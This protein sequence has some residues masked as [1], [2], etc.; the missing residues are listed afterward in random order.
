MTNYKNDFE[1]DPIIARV[2]HTLKPLPPT[3]PAAVARVLTAVHGQPRRWSERVMHRFEFLR[4]P[5]LSLAGAT[6]VA[7][8]ALLIGFVSRGAWD[9]TRDT[10]PVVTADVPV[11]T[12][13]P[14]APVANA[15]ALTP[16]ETPVPVQFVLHA[17]SA[18][19]VSLVGD[20]NDWQTDETP[21]ERVEGAGLWTATITLRPG[22]HVYSFVLDGTRW[23]RDPQAAIAADPDFGQPQSVIVVQVPRTGGNP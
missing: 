23:I 13:A 11:V 3:D 7:L 9:A 10:T 21:L 12:S 5:T 6:G 16:E 8:I 19:S 14:A 20:F 22:R 18:R 4:F 1:H 17:P 2:A 15:V